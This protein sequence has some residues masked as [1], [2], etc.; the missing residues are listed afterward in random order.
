MYSDK[1]EKNERPIAGILIVVGGI[2]AVSLAALTVV[3]GLEQTGLI[4]LQNLTDYPHYR[5]R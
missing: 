3:F 2:A 4:N 5:L 1:F